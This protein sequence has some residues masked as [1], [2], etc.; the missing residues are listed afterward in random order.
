MSSTICYQSFQ[1]SIKSALFWHYLQLLE[2]LWQAWE[3]ITVTTEW[4]HA[5]Q[6]TASRDVGTE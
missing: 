1:T 5:Q 4:S 2:E 6:S 3:I